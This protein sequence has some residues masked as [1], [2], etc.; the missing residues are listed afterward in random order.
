MI[1]FEEER[2]SPGQMLLWIATRSRQFMAALETI[3][4][5]HLEERLG[6]LQREN[7]SPNGLFI[8]TTAANHITFAIDYPKSLFESSL[9]RQLLALAD[10]L[11]AHRIGQ[12]EHMKPEYRHRLPEIEANYQEWAAKLGW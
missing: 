4:V 10:R 5:S 3:P 8:A 12:H 9:S 6:R 1:R 2:W 7:H 11:C